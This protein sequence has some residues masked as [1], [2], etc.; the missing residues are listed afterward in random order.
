MG[1]LQS[2]LI[3]SLIDRVS[4]P[5]KQAAN[6]LRGM[7]AAARSS[8]LV[9]T[10][11]VNRASRAIVSVGAGIGMYRAHE[12]IMKF[13]T[14]TNKLSAANP[15]FKVDDIREVQKLAREVSRASLFNP[16]TV[17]DA[18]NSL[19]R[20]DA[21]LEAIKGTL[22]PLATA[23]MA[24]DVPV[25]QLSDSFVKLASNFGLPMKTREEAAK[26]FQYLGDLATYV[27]Q[28]APG[29]FDDYVQAMKQVGAAARVAGIDIRWLSGAYIALDK[30][31]IR[32]EEAGTALRSLVKHLT[33]PTLEARKMYAQLGIDPA[34]FLKGGN[35]VNADQF[36]AAFQAEYGKN[37]GAAAPKIQQV[38]T[39]KLGSRER[40]NA[41]MDIVQKMWGDS[42]KPVD[43]R[44]VKKT[45]D[46]FLFSSTEMIDPQ[47]WMDELARKKVTLGQFLRLVEPKQ[48][49][50]LINLLTEQFGQ[51][52]ANKKLSEPLGSLPGFRDGLA[53][54]AGEKMLQGYPA[55][56]KRISDAFQSLIESLDKAGA[57][58]GFASALKA[59][60]DAVVSI[61]QGTAGFKDWAVGLAT[62]LPIV[63]AITPALVKLA[64]VLTSIGASIVRLTP[65]FPALAAATTAL[66]WPFILRQATEGD[67]GTTSSERLKK[68][69]GGRTMTQ[70]LRDSFNEERR[71]LGIPETKAG[72]DVWSGGA[73]PIEHLDMSGEAGSAGQ[74][75]GEAYKQSITAALAGVDPIIAAAVQRWQGMLSFTANPSVN[76]KFGPAPAASN[77][78]KSGSADSFETKKHAM[79]SDYGF[80]TG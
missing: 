17:M 39:S 63:A 11:E 77:G 64:G 35:K 18:A 69:R 10:R 80:R 68:H 6:S 57:M 34:S 24:A 41:L 7:S 55:A 32:N 73:K 8:A 20:A 71:R 4:G 16:E 25:N 46:S 58:N 26:T 33:Q 75:T 14:A 79:F 9:A 72:V 47:A 76:P 61:G 43:A 49:S 67:H 74:K 48:A 3:V 59:I 70:T 60:G 42:M 15:N 65:A 56:V 21:N 27:G 36:V 45:I 1:T 37:L 31:G 38:I 51:E 52:E 44:K 12:S 53:N 22:K 5:A 13:A 19:A 62:A 2:R 54:E 23:A 50:R 66:T 28:R 40:G 78:Q 30:A 29:S